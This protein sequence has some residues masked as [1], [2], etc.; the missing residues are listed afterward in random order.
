MTAA[1]ESLPM[2]FRALSSFALLM[3]LL[4]GCPR[5]GDD[6]KKD[7]SVN[8]DA[9]DDGGDVVACGGEVTVKELGV[10]ACTNVCDDDGDGFTDCDDFDCKGV[11]SCPGRDGEDCAAVA[12]T[13]E[14]TES[15]CSDGCDGDGDGFVD[16]DDF[17]CQ[18]VGNCFA[19]NSNVA[20]SDGLDNDGNGFIDC[21]DNGCTFCVQG[22]KGAECH[23][24]SV[25]VSEGTNLQCS[26]GMDNDGDTDVD[27]AD[28]DCQREHIVVCDGASAVDPLPAA[29]TWQTLIDA[30]CS[31]DMDDDGDGETRADCADFDCQAWSPD[32]FPGREE[33]NEA[34]SD[35]I[36]NDFDGKIDC[37]DE[38]GCQDRE[39]IV[40]CDGADEVPMGMQDDPEDRCTNNAAD[41]SDDFDDCDDFDCS[42]DSTLN[43]CA[44]QENTD[45]KCS[46]GLDNDGN[47]KIDCQD[48]DCL[49]AVGVTVCETTEAKCRDG[50]DNDGNG[51]VDCDDFGCLRFSKGKPKLPQKQA[52]FAVADPM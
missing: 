51:Y 47:D 24:L 52:C 32:C 30:K 48:F 22:K 25:C 14:T 37:A 41:D 1:K 28:E 6:A 17:G 23:V 43:V 13:E 49:D 44:D 33:G 2:T 38:F 29:N 34:C 45:T 15:L 39:Q 35:N 5:S 7:G 27:C 8:D 31:N 10:A 3:L 12:N 46:D 20:C 9:D 36:D 21:E 19:E 11:G 50:L 40:V 16:C 18:G 42:L 26:D 4:A